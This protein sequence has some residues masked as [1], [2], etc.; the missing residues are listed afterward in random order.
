MYVYVCLVFLCFDKMQSEVRLISLTLYF[1]F[2]LSSS[3]LWPFAF[4]LVGFTS[5]R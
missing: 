5:P 4:E 2:A 1:G 3:R